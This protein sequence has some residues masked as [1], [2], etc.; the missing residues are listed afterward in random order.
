MPKL[1]EIR[2]KQVLR[3]DEGEL[4]AYALRALK[5]ARQTPQSEY[6]KFE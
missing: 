4:S 1:K 5:K 6:V 2:K 3:D